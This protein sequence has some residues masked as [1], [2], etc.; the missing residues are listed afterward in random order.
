VQVAAVIRFTL[1]LALVLVAVH[2]AAL[3]AQAPGPVTLTLR[4]AD[5]RR[6]FRPGEVIPIELTFNSNVPKRFVVDG[7]T[8]DRSG[9]LTIDEFR[10]APIARVTDPMLDYF[11]AAGAFIGGGLRSM[12][13]LGE[14]PFTVRLELND[15]FRFDTP[16]AFTLSVRSNRVNDEAQSTPT[17]RLVLPV[18]SNSVSFEILTRDPRWEE[19]ELARVLG[20][21]S[22]PPVRRDLRTGCRLLRF[23]GT[24]AAVDELIRR[25]GEEECA[26]EVGVG[27]VGAP[28]RSYVVTQLETR[29]QSPDQAVT[30]DYLRTLAK[31]SLYF[32]QPE[33]RPAQ[34]PENKGRLISNGELGRRPEIL[35]AEVERYATLLASALPLKTGTARAVSAAEYAAYARRSDTTAASPMMTAASARQQL[36]ASFRD[37]PESRQRTLLDFE[38]RTVADRALLPAL[39][40][41]ANGSGE[42][43][44][45]ALRRLYQ[46]DPDEGRPRILE[47]VRRPRPGSTLKTLGALAEATLRELD[48]DLVRNAD[49]DDPQGFGLA[50]VYRYASPAVAPRIRQTIVP[51]VGQLFACLPQNYALAY[52]LRVD[53]Q[54]GIALVERALAS[55]TKTGCYRSLLRDVAR[56]RMTME[57]ESLMITALDDE[58]PRVVQNAIEALGEFGSPATLPVLR[59]HF[60]SWQRRW[61]GR[62]NELRSSQ[63]TAPDDP[64]VANQAIEMAYLR[65]LA[66][67]RRWLADSGEIA[68]LREWCVTDACRSSADLLLRQAAETTI[69]IVRF[70]A[71]DDLLA[72]V[73]QYELD[74]LLSLTRK[75]SQYPRGTN[76]TL[77]MTGGDAAQRRTLTAELTAWATKQGF[78][79]RA[80]D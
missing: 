52:F 22:A 16:G 24:P 60:D 20:L 49:P 34:T 47:A 75:L 12:G 40:T 6:Q 41:M 56:L 62:A 39:R 8:Y 4:I 32:R 17:R 63:L 7:A 10:L 73:G 13:T 48:E 36:I 55:R 67:G 70:D 76:F 1:A 69:D 15:W 45:L 14:K 54:E 71:F 43:A 57:L 33:L 30:Q 44:D 23:L 61:R 25:Y 42:V 2:E 28:D 3:P 59:S 64:G 65:A 68:A 31:I 26:F 53:P 21:L 77:R 51:A 5:G 58:H 50:L 80:G 46:L 29:L 9:R 74:S 79:V 66:V 37:L 19:D 38:W 27:L 11:A 78:V 72:R 18:E 35:Q